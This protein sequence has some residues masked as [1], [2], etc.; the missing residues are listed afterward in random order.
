M[1]YLKLL[2]Y[3][4]WVKNL[5]LFFPIF[6]GG[7]F[8]EIKPFSNTIIAFI[9]F[10]LISST[11]YIINDIKDKE[12]DALHV[13]KKNRPIASGEI[14]IITA[15]IIAII[16]FL[17]ALIIGLSIGKLFVSFMLIYFFN[18][19]I[20]T[21]YLKKI[22]YLD[23][24][25]IAIGFMLRLYSGSIASNIQLSLWL[26]VVTGAVAMMLGSGKRYE[27]LGCKLNKSIIVRDSLEKYRV[28]TIKFILISTSILS[29]VLFAIY[30]KPNNSFDFI[31]IFLSAILVFN[32]VYN[33][34]KNCIGEPTDFF[35][36][37][38]FNFIFLALW[39]V[40]FLKKIYF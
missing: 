6:F 13:K 36:K 9:A 28:E 2:R 27:E 20:Y 30:L 25:I 39:T 38:K 10:C 3:R 34:I 14:N 32:Y 31:L 4:Q 29:V 33:V 7:V 15:L 35:M 21:F 37:N 8:F 16:L 19:M 17:I 23:I 22:A 18:V 11:G 40:L 1:K 5:I 24:F 26:I 12:K